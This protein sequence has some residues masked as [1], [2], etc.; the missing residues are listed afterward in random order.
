MRER[1]DTSYITV[2][3][4][5]GH[6]ARFQYLDRCKVGDSIFCKGCRK[7][8]FATEVLR[9][10]EWCIRCQECGYSQRAGQSQMK[11]GRLSGNHA[12]KRG[13]V[14]RTYHERNPE[15]TETFSGK[16]KETLSRYE[17]LLRDAGANPDEPPPF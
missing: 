8:V 9:D 3:L 7:R 15:G 1:S 14:V 6:K 17:I 11:A 10:L 5:C 16:R 12:S 4:S 13:H 2:S